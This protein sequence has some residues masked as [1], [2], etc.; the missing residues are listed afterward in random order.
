VAKRAPSNVLRAWWVY[1]IVVAPFVALLTD[2]LADQHSDNLLLA[3]YSVDYPFDR[4]LQRFLPLLQFLAAPINDYS[5][6]LRFQVLVRVF[7]FCFVILWI[8]RRVAS[9]VSGS[10]LGSALG[11]TVLACYF[12]ARFPE[13]NDSLV[14]G[15]SP[16]M[17]ASFVFI[18]SMFTARQ[19]E[20]SC[21]R[22][23][24]IVLTLIATLLATLSLL[25]YFMLVLWAPALVLLEIL[26][27]ARPASRS[28]V[29]MLRN[30][31]TKSLLLICVLAVSTFIA[32]GYLRRSSS[33]QTSVTFG[34]V[35]GVVRWTRYA[36][37]Q[38]NLYIFENL[39]LVLALSI[40]LLVVARTMVSLIVSG[41]ATAT[42]GGVF[43]VASLDHVAENVHLPRYYAPSLFVGLLIAFAGLSAVVGRRIFSSWRSRPPLHRP[44]FANLRQHLV[45]AAGAMKAV[46]FA[47]GVSAFVMR[48]V[49][50]GFEGADGQ[51]IR[52][53]GL[54]M[55][56][57]ELVV[58]GERAK[59]PIDFV[60]GSY[61]HVWTTVFKAGEE[62]V[63]VFPFAPFTRAIDRANEYIPN[64]PVYG[65][66]M[67]LDVRQC[68]D[69][70][71]WV[72]PANSEWRL[73]VLNRVDIGNGRVLHLVRLGRGG[74][75]L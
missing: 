2:A 1:A 53:Q 19:V 73:D 59:K 58:A 28:L 46:L 25:N 5:A 37:D 61:W 12:L 26:A 63:H 15:A 39:C 38:G 18:M 6:N 36:W 10:F 71:Q 75:S 17:Q 31:L 45:P 27:R 66:C 3:V 68:D 47:V 65:L 50:F 14:Y 20:S 55:S 13:A 42:A 22:G 4:Y 51:Q 57:F 23:N 74:Q 70:V 30:I 8:A 43:V 33:E 49:G 41:V 35:L 11:A 64:S 40:V 29:S 48:P 34:R 56:A 72:L 69:S 44:F 60:M 9:A 67:D 32:F 21:N 54:P 24:K 52:K 62:G 7:S 16:S